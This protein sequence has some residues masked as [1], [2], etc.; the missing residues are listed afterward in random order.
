MNNAFLY[1]DEAEGFSAFYD[2]K[3]NMNNAAIALPQ[4]RKSLELLL[5]AICARE[6][7][8]VTP[9]TVTTKNGTQRREGELE[10]LIKSLCGGTTSIIPKNVWNI[11][12]QN[13]PN[14]N[15]LHEIRNEG[16]KSIHTS[17]ESQ[18]S[19]LKNLVDSYKKN[20]I[21]WYTNKYAIT[22]WENLL[23]RNS[24]NKEIVEISID[25]V[26]EQLISETAIK[27][28]QAIA[29]SIQPH[30][31]SPTAST[32]TIALLKGSYIDS[33][34]WQHYKIKKENII[35]E[36][37]H[38]YITPVFSHGNMI[39]KVVANDF[40]ILPNDD[41][42][43]EQQ[44]PERKQYKTI[45]EVF[46]IFRL[47]NSFKCLVKVTGLGGSGKT[48]FL[49]HLAKQYYADYKTFFLDSFDQDSL[50][51]IEQY[52]NKE[53]DTILILLDSVYDASKES[54]LKGFFRRLN[55]FQK[56]IF[57]ISE[58]SS[59]LE[60]IE[61]KNNLYS[62][63]SY[64]FEV[65][66]T[67]GLNREK[68]FE[69][70]TT[71]LLKNNEIS[72]DTSQT[73][74]QDNVSL[75]I[76]KYR[77]LKRLQVSF[78]EL[79][80]FSFDWED[81]EKFANIHPKYS[82]F[83][84]LYL[85][86]SAFQHLGQKVPSKL[87]FTVIFNSK[88]ASDTLLY[89]AIGEFGEEKCPISYK[90]IEK[91][92][93]VFASDDMQ[94]EILIR[95]EI[96]ISQKSILQNLLDRFFSSIKDEESIYLFRNIHRVR[97]FQQSDLF[98]KYL[99][100]NNRIKILSEYLNAIPQDQ[101]G[102]NES[103]CLTELIKTH[104]EENEEEKMLERIF[105]LKT[106]EEKIKEE[107]KKTNFG[108]HMLANYYID[109]NKEDK[110]EEAEQLLKEIQGIT[111]RNN[112]DITYSSFIKLYSKYPEDKIPAEWK[113]ILAKTE[114]AVSDDVRISMDKAK[115]LYE[116]GNIEDA[117][118]MYQD[119]IKDDD[120]DYHSRTKLSSCLRRIAHKT[121]NRNE[122]IQL[123]T[124]AINHSLNALSINVKNEHTYTELGETFFTL[125][126]NINNKENIQ[127]AIDYLQQGIKNCDNSIGCKTSLGKIY[128]Y[129][130]NNAYE[131]EVTDSEKMDYLQL[132][133]KI[134]REAKA[135]PVK[136][137]PSS[138]ELSI[139]CMRLFEL[140]GKDNSNK[141][142]QSSFK[143]EIERTLYS[144]F[145]DENELLIQ[146]KRVENGIRLLLT[147]YQEHNFT[148]EYNRLSNKILNAIEPYQGFWSTLIDIF[149]NDSSSLKKLFA[150][151][152][153]TIN[154]GKNIHKIVN[155][156]I[157]PN[158][159][160]PNVAQ[161]IEDAIK[162]IGEN[163]IS[164]KNGIFLLASYYYSLG[165]INECKRILNNYT[166]KLSEDDTLFI[167]QEFIKILS[168]NP[169][170]INLSIVQKGEHNK[171]SFYFNE[172]KKLKQS[173]SGAISDEIKNSID[174]GGQIGYHKKL[175]EWQ[176]GITNLKSLNKLHESVFSYANF[177]IY[178]VIGELY[179][180]RKEI[181]LISDEYRLKIAKNNYESAYL[182][183]LEDKFSYLETSS[184]LNTIEANQSNINYLRLFYFE[185]LIN[186]MVDTY[187]HIHHINGESIFIGKAFKI[188]ENRNIKKNIPFYNL[189]K[190][191]LFTREQEYKM[192]YESCQIGLIEINHLIPFNTEMSMYKTWVNI[193]GH[194]LAN[195]AYALHKNL[196]ENKKP[197]EKET[198]SSV[199]RIYQEAYKLFRQNWIKNKINEL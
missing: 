111:K 139:T 126:K 123:L 161:P 102:T 119:I 131:L 150:N 160:I 189:L 125:S 154:D 20:F 61:D 100:Y 105:Q 138:I 93:F 115:R 6:N 156:L 28:A 87:D 60:N 1:N 164:F 166:D 186:N 40:Y 121:K 16:N 180:R 122:K 177:Y 52:V 159:D 199:K 181:P 41:L 141:E 151:I 10:S 94:S 70:L 134:L 109:F 185:R 188:I 135:E 128:R 25:L 23:K 92:D 49:W 24:Q 152:I 175:L 4:L 112:Q 184:T 86:L 62:S 57:T 176:F 174:V 127:K 74:N 73:I 54:D 88:D 98:S 129:V 192:A 96:S 82:G 140:H 48:T 5:K 66:F 34:F 172:A 148:N 2:V 97:N 197:I 9:Q 79:K 133:L 195:L 149:K 118:L 90:E 7:I 85:F 167:W 196:I 71:L 106:Y 42:K 83:K 33:A 69:K 191:K 12:K 65:P 76:Q 55:S 147:F 130:Y 108:K 198:L 78:P 117:I 13:F 81:W 47:K 190:S 165:S 45:D 157:N 124:T 39:E 137:Q 37:K 84:H 145:F 194:L 27:T 29:S 169:F 32:N 38:F 182:L 153:F 15:F 21:N 18:I 101:Y 19:L 59:W 17:T 110:Y 183:A 58:R 173:T 143:A 64:E 51:A 68:V 30:Y 8:T 53:E 72:F 142:L 116:E 193:E 31:T 91:K 168:E 179:H 158:Y 146:K 46:S 162:T 155:K 75:V 89:E 22:N 114:T 95:E 144:T 104:E 132:S 170:Y 43:I 36:L 50:S 120:N 80:L 178:L 103:K 3:C 107:H 171:Q 11:P 163:N 99:N 44:S 56:V 77:F 136:H 14:N 63:F 67:K 113:I 187:L 35:D 26:G